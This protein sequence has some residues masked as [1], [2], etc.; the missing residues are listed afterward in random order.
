MGTLKGFYDGAN[1]GNNIPNHPPLISA[2]YYIV[3]PIHSSIMWFLSNLGNFI[4]LNRLAPTKF[5]WLFNFAIWFG[6]KHYATTSTLLGIII[7]LKIV[8]IA[9]DF[10]IGITIY[11]LCRKAKIDYFKP[12]L[13]YLILPFSWYL[14]SS[15]G[16]SDQLSFIFLLFSVIALYSN[17][18]TLSSPVFFAL[19]A[20]LKPNCLLILPLYLFSWYQQKAG[21]KNLII[22][23]LTAILFTFWTLSWFTSQNIFSFAINDLIPKI[24]TSGG[25]INFNAFNFWYIFYP[26]AQ[27][28][29]YYDSQQFL[30]ISAKIWGLIATTIFAIFGLM[31]IKKNKIQSFFAAMFI[32]VFGSWLFLTGMHERYAF[33]GILPLLL[34]SI[35]NKKY[36]KYFLLLSTIFTLNIFLAYWPWDNIG[37]VSDS[38]KSNSYLIP[39]LLSLINIII[40]VRLTT[41]L[42]KDGRLLPQSKKL[43]P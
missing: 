25:L 29:N 27:K 26:Y 34:Y 11:Y 3:Y 13:L 30:F 8:M 9:A 7:M 31:V 39:R 23:S 18:Y 19:A 35:F 6:T 32:T 17:K 28:I 37:W 22:G 20:N 5:L 12:V 4:A 43:S 33:L 1:W 15:W 38:L 42:I 10:S 36:L 21:I 40:Y 2:L 14:S 16:Q 24:N 41:S